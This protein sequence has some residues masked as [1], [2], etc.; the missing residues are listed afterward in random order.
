MVGA[1]TS[2]SK[3][4]SSKPLVKRKKKAVSGGCG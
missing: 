1:G 4:K 2:S 3:P